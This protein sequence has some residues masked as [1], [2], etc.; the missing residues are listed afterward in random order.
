MKNLLIL[1]Y[2]GVI[3]SAC[4]KE[5][6][7]EIPIAPPITQD[8]CPRSLRVG[9]TVAV[10]A[11][12]NFV[13]RESLAA[14]ID[15][16]RHWGLVVLEADNLYAQD[17]R[18]A[19]TVQERTLSLQKM[20]DN[21]S[22]RAIIMARGGYGAAQIINNIDYSPLLHSPKWLIGY[23]DVTAFH[24]AFNNLGI[25][26]IHGTMIQEFNN[27]NKS[28]ALNIASLKTALWG[29]LK[30]H[31]IPTNPYCIE[32]DAAG[33]LVGG[34][35]SLIYSLQ[36]TSFDLNTR[37]SILFLED[38]D[39]SGYSIDRMMTNLALSGKLADVKGVVIGGLTNVTSDYG[40]SKEEIMYNKLRHLNIPVLFGLEAGHDAINHALYLGR[41]VR[42]HVDKNKSSIQFIY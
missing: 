38:V 36:G 2:L 7:T 12:S 35:L 42:L 14:G 19:G 5:Y 8:I 11:A 31:Q 21:P 4:T 24:I 34:N 16:L 28:F 13:T 17:G 10:C 32:G 15:T 20:I 1:F 33:R 25:E 6:Y 18:Y 23:S 27:P 41:N 26:T 22:V 29:K 9:D 39:E 30:E 3:L 37:S 40:L